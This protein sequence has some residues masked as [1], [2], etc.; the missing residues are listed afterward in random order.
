[1][2]PNLGKYC[3]QHC[4]GNRIKVSVQAPP[5]WVLCEELVRTRQIA[6]VSFDLTSPEDFLAN[7]SLY[8]RQAVLPNLRTG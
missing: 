2:R 3:S 1:M 4:S 8:V 6:Q 7:L 5:R